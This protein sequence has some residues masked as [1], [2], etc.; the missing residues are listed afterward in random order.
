MTDYLAY[1][2]KLKRNV[3]V[4]HTPADHPICFDCRQWFDCEGR[5]PQCY[6]R[7]DNNAEPVGEEHLMTHNEFKMRSK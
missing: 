2:P 3:H 5:C 4:Q 1:S 6:A 7:I